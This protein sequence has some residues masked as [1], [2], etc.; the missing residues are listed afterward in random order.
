MLQETTS[1]PKKRS[2][3]IIVNCI[4]CGK[5]I[6]KTK[7]WAARSNN[8]L[9]SPECWSKW[10]RESGKFRGENNPTWK[11][12]L[13]TLEC[14]MCGKTFERYKSDHK[15]SKNIFCSLG[16][17]QK[18]LMTNPNVRDEYPTKFGSG[19]HGGAVLVNCHTCGKELVRERN[20]VKHRK[21]AFCDRK[22]WAA[23]RRSDEWRKENNPT[24]KPE[25][26]DEERYWRT[27]IEPALNTWIKNVKLRD[28]RT[29]RVCGKQQKFMIAHH[30]NSWNAFPALRVDLENGICLC[31]ECHDSFHKIYGKGENTHKQFEMFMETYSK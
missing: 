26:P 2:I 31:V 7:S 10:A 21:L 9:C 12:A 16:C 14:K 18:Y 5:E 20:Q 11:G 6:S 4:V 22:C 3:R 23:W 1:S 13:Q 17:W 27:H 29:C 15:D 28:N 25:K 30:L 19:C 24:Y 8:H